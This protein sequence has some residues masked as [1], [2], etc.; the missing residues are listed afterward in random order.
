MNLIRYITALLPPTCAVRLTEV[1]VEEASVRA[2]T[3]G[4]GADRLLPALC[5]AVVVHP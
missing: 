5:R 2:P 4:D 3:H 1:T